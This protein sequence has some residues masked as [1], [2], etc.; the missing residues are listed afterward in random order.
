MCENLV[1]RLQHCLGQIRQVVQSSILKASILHGS[2]LKLVLQV[3]GL[4]SW[5]RV[6][7]L[8]GEEGEGGG[9]AG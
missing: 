7:A 4:I 2:L 5:H 1:Q 8:W 9:W 6:H 3:L